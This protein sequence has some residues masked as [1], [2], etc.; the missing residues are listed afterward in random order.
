MILLEKT[1]SAIRRG[2]LH[3]EPLTR[4]LRFFKRYVC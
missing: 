1:F 2:M 3:M 4:E